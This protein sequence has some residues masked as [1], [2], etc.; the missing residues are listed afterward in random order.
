MIGGSRLANASDG[1]SDGEEPWL[2][3]GR[4]PFQFRVGDAAKAIV[5]REAVDD[6]R[7]LGS[8][9][10]HSAG[11]DAWVPGGNHANYCGSRNHQATAHPPFIF[12]TVL[13]SNVLGDALRDCV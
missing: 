10:C 5:P 9:H 7:H 4:Q 2:A 1:L 6:R 3:V 13:C 8:V 11:E 12:V